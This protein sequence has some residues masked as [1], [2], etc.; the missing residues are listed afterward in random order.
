MVV[1]YA[2]TFSFSGRDS[3]DGRCLRSGNEYVS[4]LT[5]LMTLP[6]FLSTKD[7]VE[8]GLVDHDDSGGRTRITSTPDSRQ[9]ISIG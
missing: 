1:S 6:S 9:N 7:V 8:W 3:A 2:I 4:A 5:G